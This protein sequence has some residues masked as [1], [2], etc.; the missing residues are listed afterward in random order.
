M[1]PDKTEEDF[2]ASKGWLHSFKNC[3]RIKQ[4]I[5]QGEPLS[6][7]SGAADDYRILFYWLLV[8]EEYYSR[9]HVF[10]ADETGR[11]QHLLSN[12]THSG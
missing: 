4:L 10:N 8:M 9:H 1:Y 7:D 3:H 12:N 11:Y 5:L 2:E 6:A